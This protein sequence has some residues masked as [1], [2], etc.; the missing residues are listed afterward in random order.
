MKALVG[1]G[2]G[3]RGLTD[4]ELRSLVALLR[5]VRVGAGELTDPDP[6]SG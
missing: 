5:K 4:A 3:V 6:A 1:D 2:F